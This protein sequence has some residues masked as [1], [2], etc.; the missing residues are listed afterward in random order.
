MTRRELM[1]MLEDFATTYLSYSPS[2]SICTNAH[3]TGY[4]G[5]RLIP[6]NHVSAVLVDFINYVG[7]R[8]G[9]DEC[10]H[11]YHLKKKLEV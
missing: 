5:K 3:L 4:R 7:G 10:L 8:Q 1:D 6:H 2:A 11:D 9:L